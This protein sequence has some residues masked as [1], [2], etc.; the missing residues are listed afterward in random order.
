LDK[1]AVS[2]YLFNTSAT[3]YFKDSYSNTTVGQFMPVINGAG[4][5]LIDRLTAGFVNITDETLGAPNA[6]DVNATLLN[7]SVSKVDRDQYYIFTCSRCGIPE[8][9]PCVVPESGYHLKMYF[10][11]YAPYKYFIGSQKIGASFTSPTVSA[12]GCDETGINY[13]N[14]ND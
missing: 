1:I 7:Y 13:V 5:R 4:E 10:D 2:E 6:A 14:I 12:G 3:G 8:N 9:D 11:T